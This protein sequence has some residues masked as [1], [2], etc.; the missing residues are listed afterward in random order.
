MH[1]STP[2]YLPGGV[3]LSTAPLETWIA[4]LPVLPLLA[5]LPRTTPLPTSQTCRATHPWLA[6]SFHLPKPPPAHLLP[7]APTI[8][9][10]EVQVQS[11]RSALDHPDEPHTVRGSHLIRRCYSPAPGPPRRTRGHESLHTTQ[12]SVSSP[13]L[14]LVHMS[15]RPAWAWTD[16]MASTRWPST[17]GSPRMNRMIPTH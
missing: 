7:W 3:K 5:P 11:I 12:P 16:P 15:L 8:H 17:A 9:P 2:R 6:T 1:S 14:P 13:G 4:K 10:T